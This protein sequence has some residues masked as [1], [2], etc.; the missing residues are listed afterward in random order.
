TGGSSGIG[1]MIATGFV[2][3]GAKTYIASRKKEVCEDVADELSAFGTC[4]P[5]QADLSSLDGVN[6]LADTIK[7]EEG[8]LDI[9]VNNS[10]AT[11]GAP[12]DEFPESGWDKV[13]DLNVK[14]VFFLIQQL[15]GHLRTNAA[16]EKPSKIVN[17]ASI[18]GLTVPDLE[19]YS[20]S[21]SKAAVIHMTRVL[22]RWLAEDKI[23]VNAIAPGPFPSRMMRATLEAHEERII[24][25]VPMGRVGE[26]EDMAGTALFLASRASDYITGACIPVDGGSATTV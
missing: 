2:Q 22:A 24:N 6:S 15:R 11:W 4:I 17:I 20:Y 19:T 25:R 1:K 13:F 14:A 26:P 16:P 3:N 12:L 23:N 10:G 8:G 18:N 7:S 9:L 5:L 21:A